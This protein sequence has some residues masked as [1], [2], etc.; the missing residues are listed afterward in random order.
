M[1]IKTG[2][3]GLIIEVAPELITIRTDY[4]RRTQSFRNA[5]VTI[6]TTGCLIENLTSAINFKK[7]VLGL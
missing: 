2:P 1:I 3:R 5:A 4:S 6:V 7:R